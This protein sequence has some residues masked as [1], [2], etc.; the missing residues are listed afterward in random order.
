LEAILAACNAWLGAGDYVFASLLMAGLVGSLIHCSVMCSPLVA[1]Q[2]LELHEKSRP[3]RLMG[4]Y[5]LGRIS[6]YAGLGIVSVM[7]G[8]W[9]FGGMI[10]AFAHVMLMLAGCVFIFSALMP[11]KTHHDCCATKE[12]RL[13]RVLAKLNKPAAIMYARGVAMGFMPCGMVLAALLLT[14]T[15]PTPW[16][17]AFG[18]ALFGL[19]TSP[20][21]HVTGIG[22]L[23]LNRYFPQ[24]TR[25]AGR[26]VMA[27]NGLLLC[28]ISTNLI[29]VS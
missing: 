16:H 28:A 10:N 7:L 2:M 14:A 5:H 19:A 3:Q 24:A 17:A 25:V 23:R 6:T 11:R 26:G 4:A 1:A 9:L 18:M 12:G 15:L 20:I 8:Q 29:T 21:L 13:Q 22:A 27:V